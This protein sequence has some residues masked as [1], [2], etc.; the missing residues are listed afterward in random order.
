MY[1]YNIFF[2]WIAHINIWIELNTSLFITWKYYHIE[3]ITLNIL[4]LLKYCLS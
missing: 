4:K 2:I 3:K 1:I